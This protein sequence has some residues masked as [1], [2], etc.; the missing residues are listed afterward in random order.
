MVG[1]PL[2][3]SSR[4]Q[5]AYKA[6]AKF[7]GLIKDDP[8][9]VT[10]TWTGTDVCNTYKGISCA[11]YPKDGKKAVYG[12]DFNN[13]C[14]AG[15]GEHLPVDG[16][17]EGI[18][19]LSFIHANS[20]NFTGTVP[21]SI[22][23]LPYLYELDFS[24][25]KLSGPVPSVV[26]SSPNLTFVDLR[27]NMFSGW[28]PPRIFTLDLDFLFINNNRF[29]PQQLPD[30]LGTPRA[31]FISLANSRYV[32]PIPSSIGGAAK[33]LVEIL[34]LNNNLSGCLPTEIGQL[35]RLRY[36]NAGQNQLTGPIPLSFACL[37]NMQSLSL[38]ENLM[39]GIVP[40]MVCQLPLLSNFSLA[41]NYFTEVGP[42]CRK[43]IASGRLDLR[44]NCVLDLPYQRSRAE[45]AAFFSNHL[46]CPQESYLR[47]HIPCSVAAEEPSSDAAQLSALHFNPVSY[48][49]LTPHHSP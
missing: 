38:A 4:I 12:L 41:F 40:E 42:E 45:C 10:R 37:R 1:P 7:R 26:L 27:F 14:F 9:Q 8:K 15:H 31:L 6:I 3:E 11:I 13:F 17:V 30:T 49:A 44:M 22:L 36:F 21:A 48:R 35:V 29:A 2:F 47:T 25:N 28:V 46:P 32:G 34:L 33:R 20:N 24:N 19:E 18:P 5:T 43:L 16:L 23:K 39:Y